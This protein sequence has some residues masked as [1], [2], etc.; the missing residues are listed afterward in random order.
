MPVTL[1]TYL[2]SKLEPAEFPEDARIDAARLGASLTLAKG[3]LLGKRTSD[4]K[5]YAYDD[6]KTD[7]TERA[8]GILVYDTITDASGNHY[9][10][11]SATASAINLPHAD[12][13]VYVAG[14]FDTTE[15][16]GYNAA[17]LADFQGY[18]LPSGY[19]RFG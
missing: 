11:T 14:T 9:T 7:G 18:L 19:I 10:G 17:A 8:V 1:D 5:H 4:N 15:L 13:S 16:T 3:T 6:T 2:P 12:C